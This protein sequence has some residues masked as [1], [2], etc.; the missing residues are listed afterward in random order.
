MVTL[1]EKRDYIKKYIPFVDFLAEILGSNSEVLL[2]DLTD[3]D[4]SVLAIRNA[5]VSHRKVGDP[6]TDLALETMKSGQRRKE[7]FIANY[8]SVDKQGRV[9]R[10]STYFIRY[11]GEL[12]AMICI[13]TDDSIINGMNTTINKLV[14]EYSK[15][16]QLQVAIPEKEVSKSNAASDSVH[17]NVG[18]HHTSVKTEHLTTSLKDM[19]GSE[20]FRICE[21]RNVNVDYLKLNDKIELVRR[22]YHNG[23]FLLKDAVTVVASLIQVSEPTLYRYLQSVKNEEKR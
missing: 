21:E 18:L 14:N 16:K 3:L 12:V 22:L 9:L 4:H 2:N 20:I 8:Q 17:D 13:N 19:A 5:E 23:Y 6:A 11:E 10:S 1:D 15:L 7:N